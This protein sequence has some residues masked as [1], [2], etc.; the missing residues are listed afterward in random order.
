MSEI[1][2]IQTKVSKLFK[3]AKILNDNLLKIGYFV[4]FF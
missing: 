3:S 2:R 1:T 4:F